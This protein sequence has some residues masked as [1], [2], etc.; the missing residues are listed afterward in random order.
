MKR[1]GFTLSGKTVLIGT[2]AVGLLS[3]GLPLSDAFGVGTWAYPDSAAERTER[4]KR[5]D[6]ELQEKNTLYESNYEEY[7]KHSEALAKLE[8]DIRTAEQKRDIHNR[9]AAEALAK[10]RQAQ[11][12]SLVDPKISTEP[13]R[14]ALVQA[15]E[16]VAEAVKAQQAVIDGLKIQLPQAREKINSA[17]AR[18]NAILR[19]IDDLVKHRE[20]VS[21]MMFV[22]SVAD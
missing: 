20:A 2:V 11:A 14:L 12:V 13:Q 3:A 1:A 18:L 6:T 5:L 17:H 19:Q 9:P 10:Y 22:R 8:S 15:R 7:V 16:A 4:I 21:E